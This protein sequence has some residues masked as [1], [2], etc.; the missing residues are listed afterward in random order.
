M[1][2]MATAFSILFQKDFLVV[3]HDVTGSRVTDMLEE[4]ALKNRI[5]TNDRELQIKSAEYNED[6]RSR[7]NKKINDSVQFIKSSINN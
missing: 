4:L 1:P 3:P 6:F 2:L 5:V 7:L